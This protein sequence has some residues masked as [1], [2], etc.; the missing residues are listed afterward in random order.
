MREHDPD[1]DPPTADTLAGEYV[2][3]VLDER[4]RRDVRLRIARDPAFARLVDDWSRRLDALNDELPQ[5]AVPDHVWPRIRTRLGWS[6]VMSSRDPD[7]VGRWKA[8]AAAG[9]AAAAVLAV[10]ALQKPRAITAPAPQVATQ[11]APKAAA[12]MPE[13]PVTRLVKD[14]GQIAYLATVDMHGGGMWLVPVPGAMSEDGMAPVL[15]LL[16]PGQKPKSLGYVGAW[17]SHWVDVP[18]AE[19]HAGMTS[20]W[21][22]AITME[23]VQPV[24]PQSPSSKPMAAGTLS[25]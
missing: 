19:L 11:A 21:R 10:V 3:G 17:K 20:G 22:V 1:R 5:A 15:W 13:M 12:P 8:A 6:P 18:K 23:P 2:L 14:D 25:L 4:E 7:G 9:F 16:A 24:A